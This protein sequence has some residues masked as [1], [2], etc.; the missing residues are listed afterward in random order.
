MM[1]TVQFVYAT[2]SYLLYQDLQDIYCRTYLLQ[3][4]LLIQP[5]GVVHEFSIGDVDWSE[6]F[7]SKHIASALYDCG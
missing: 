7:W 1:P 2:K 6:E 4:K 3:D 5:I